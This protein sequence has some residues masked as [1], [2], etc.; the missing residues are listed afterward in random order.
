MVVV[1]T[2]AICQTRDR[3]LCES[4]L[5][6]Q[7]TLQLFFR[8]GR[9]RYPNQPFESSGDM[10]RLESPPVT[11]SSGRDPVGAHDAEPVACDGND[12]GCR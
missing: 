2:E 4:L 11:V 12:R 6:F 3:T 1:A 8:L 10:V 5:F 9:P 7:P